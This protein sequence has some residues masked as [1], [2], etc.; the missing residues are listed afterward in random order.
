MHSFLFL[1][2][3]H[4]VLLVGKLVG[5]G[6]LLRSAPLNTL[7]AVIDG[8]SPVVWLDEQFVLF[9]SSG[10]PTVSRGKDQ[11]NL[12]LRESV[13]FDSREHKPVWFEAAWRDADGVIW[14][15]YHHEPAGVCP[16]NSLSAPRIGAA[17]SYDGGRTVKDLGIIL[18]AGD[19][20]D[21]DAKNGFFASGHGDFSVVPDR[22]GEYFYFFFTNYGG[23]PSGQGVA[24]ARMAFRDRFYPQDAVKKFFAGEWTEPGRGGR[25]EPIFP[26]TQAW[27]REDADSFWGPAVHWNESIGSFVMLLNRA[28][29]EPGWPQ[30]G[31]YVS[32][33]ANISDPRSWKSPQKILDASALVDAPGYYP[34]VIGLK[35]GE[36]DSFAGEVS[37]LYIHGKSRWEIHFYPAEEPPVGESCVEPSLTC[38]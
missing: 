10:V 16:N 11:F 9:H 21:C 28:C 38:R 34:Q 26:A 13:W 32:F 5:Q 17:V 23:P 27:Q 24:V 12:P 18:E 1:F 7:P 36:T 25:I 15:W 6:V 3:A 33:N 8:N 31:I 20:P 22:E 35:A 2:V 37:R 4:V 30:E 14:L 29:C 19:A